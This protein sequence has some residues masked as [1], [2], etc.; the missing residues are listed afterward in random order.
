VR[1]AR[2]KTTLAES[3]INVRK[4]TGKTDRQTDEQTRTP[5]R[6]FTLITAVDATNVMNDK[7]NAHC[8]GSKVTVPCEPSNHGNQR[9][10]R[11]L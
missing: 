3:R 9:V 6:C 4:N 7:P 5:D 11:D 2:L 10:G 1:E 8:K